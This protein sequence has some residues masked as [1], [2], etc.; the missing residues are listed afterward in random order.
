MQNLPHEAVI[1]FLT[2]IKLIDL[3]FKPFLLFVQK[4]SI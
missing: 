2:K 1:Q 3:H 4:I